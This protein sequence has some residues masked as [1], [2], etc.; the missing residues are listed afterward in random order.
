MQ[1]ASAPSPVEVDRPTTDEDVRPDVPWVVIVWNDPINL[2]SYVTF[3][4][5]KLFGYSL[6]KATKL[7]LDVHQ[8][9]KAVVSS[10][11]RDK[12]RGRRVPPAPVRPVGHDAKGRLMIGAGRRIRRTRSGEFALRFPDAERRMLRALPGQLRELLGGIGRPADHAAVPSGLHAGR[13][14]RGGVPRARSRRAGCGPARGARA[15]GVDDR[16]PADHRG[17]AARLGVGVQRSS[18]RARNPAERHRGAA[19][20]SHRRGRSGGALVRDVRVSHVARGPG[21][22]GA[23]ARAND[24][25]RRRDAS[26]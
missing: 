5:Q 3:V 19:P 12:A 26:S 16:R 9:G 14:A 4:F 7:M 17:A 6:E 23:L 25:A 22:R 1:P 15:D 18:A 13:S 8:R 24:G 10:G 2:M 11:P 21:R 20:R